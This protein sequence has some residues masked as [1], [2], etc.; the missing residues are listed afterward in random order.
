MKYLSEYLGVTIRQERER[1][2]LSLRDVSEMAYISLGYLSEVERGLKEVSSP[3]LNS[4]ADALHVS[5]G[6]I[7]T[8]TLSEVERETA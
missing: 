4:I 5:L 8:K 7:L 2:K 3:V 6:D 1:Q